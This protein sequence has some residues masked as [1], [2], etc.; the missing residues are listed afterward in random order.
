[1]DGLSDETIAQLQI[2]LLLNGEKCYAVDNNFA[3]KKEVYE[4]DPSRENQVR[5][6]S[7]C[8]LYNY[9]PTYDKWCLTCDKREGV[10]KRCGGCRAVF[11]C[12]RKCQIKAWPIHQNHCGRDLFTL[13]ISC[14]STSITLE[15][16][17]CPVKWCSQECKK[18]LQQD[19]ED[20]D[21]DYF[22]TTFN[23]E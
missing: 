3:Y 14:G 16:P 7:D 12:N 21:C 18:R 2:N 9:V 20:F 8:K 11:F 4:A 1:M 19:H 6:L 5:M 17:K 23:H 10:T 13:C 15:C 22:A